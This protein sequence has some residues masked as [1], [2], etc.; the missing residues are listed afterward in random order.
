MLKV[1]LMTMDTHSTIT[2]QALL[3]SGATGLFIDRRFIHNNRLKTRVLPFPI[4]VYN[5]DGTLNQGRS[6]TEE[7]TLMMSH[8]GHKEKA[9]FKVCD[10]GK[11]III[12]GHPWLWK[13]NLEVN[14][15]TGEV[16]MTRC[17]WECNVFIQ[18]A[19]KEWKQKR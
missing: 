2:V 11:A 16:K 8:K 19:K 14:W 10:L 6:I 9:V 4:K 12:I 1:G 13:H 18:V 17:P 5:V 7:I 15:S 3:D